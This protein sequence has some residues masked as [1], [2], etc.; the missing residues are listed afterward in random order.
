MGLELSILLLIVAVFGTVKLTAGDKVF[1]LL[2][3]LLSISGL[4]IILSIFVTSQ[5]IIDISMVL[6]PWLIFICRLIKIDGVDIS[7]T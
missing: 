2:L 1:W 3:S 4:P 5:L 6:G 7:S